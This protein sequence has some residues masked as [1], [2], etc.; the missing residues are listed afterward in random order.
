MMSILSN[1]YV[2]LKHKKR[3][4]PTLSMAALPEVNIGIFG[5]GTVGGGIVE[6]IESKREH[7]KK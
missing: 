4:A 5:G 2:N 3:T 1:K 7:L 6:I